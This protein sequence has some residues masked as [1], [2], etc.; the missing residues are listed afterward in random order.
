MSTHHFQ[1]SAAALTLASLLLLPASPVQAKEY[2]LKADRFDLPD[3]NGGSTPIAMWGY[4][5]CDDGSLRVC[6]PLS[7]PGP[8]LTLPEG[9][10]TL[11]VHLANQLSEPTSLVIHGLLKS[12]APVWTT[13]SKGRRRV[14]SFDVEAPPNGLADY[15]WTN[16]KPG[17][18][19]Y[20][21]GTQPQVQV[22][23]GLYGALSKNAVDPVGGSSPVQAQAYAGASYAFDAQATLLYSEIDPV[24]HAAVAAG[25]Y[26]QACP[27][28]VPDCGNLSSTF[29]YQ[30]RYFLI[31]G[32]PYQVGAPLVEPVPTSGPSGTRTLVRLLNAGLTTHVPMVQGAYWD[33]VA[34]DG[35][36]YPFRARQ[37]TA[38]L[39]AAKTLDLLLQRPAGV[40]YAIMDRRL[41]LSN[42]GAP[43]GGMLALLGSAGGAVAGGGLG[44]G[45]ADSGSNQPPVAVADA[46]T[47]V[48][49]ARLHLAAPGVLANDDPTDG[50]ALGAVAVAQ[51]VTACGGS[52]ALSSNGAF[53]YRPPRTLTCAD[54]SGPNADQFTGTD[55]FSY[56]A[57]D[58]ALQSAPV[59]VTISLVI[60]K[61]PALTLLDDFNRANGAT[62]G[63]ASVAGEPAVAWLQ[64]ATS[65]A[66]SDLVLTS[67]A[68]KAN[69]VTLGGLAILNHAFGPTQ[70]AG[71]AMASPL[72]EAAVVLKASGGT[73][74][75]APVN[76]VRVRCETGNG[77][78]LVV[79]T[80]LGGSNVSVYARQAGF[81][82]SDCNGSGAL[83]ALA[84]DKGLVTTFLNGTFVGAVQLPDV[85]AWKGPGMVGIQLQNPIA[86]V[87][88]FL[89]GA[90]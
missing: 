78:E 90:F 60:P 79:A 17:T 42:S 75:A 72:A 33:V 85:A 7:A 37:Y 11:T 76:Y 41:N 77:G 46:Y 1:R 43:N 8:A 82:A 4:A 15:I 29:N 16:V 52:Y 69:S 47:S 50:P 86:T 26:G 83:R 63:L 81:A 21:S 32:Q 68:A 25:S 24:L 53:T 59:M 67:N 70:G 84:D 55:S 36:P 71:F 28:Q 73:N 13:D 87:D 62:L 12:M 40:S 35:K 6:R 66:G 31:N 9:D 48:A 64:Q 5:D 65:N 80:M 38:L 30:P 22:Q 49:G 45:T 23:M 14:R 61:A 88:D 18:Y 58:G 27:E 20:Q 57:S 51:G 3:P 39:P 54:L 19:L 10:S 44:A 34:E 56:R 89:G 2:F 74:P